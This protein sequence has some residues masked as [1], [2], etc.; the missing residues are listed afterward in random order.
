MPPHR[1]RDAVTPSLL[2]SPARV[3]PFLGD[4][5]LAPVIVRRREHQISG[6]DLVIFALDTDRMRSEMPIV[7]QRV[8]II[9]A[10]LPTEFDRHEETAA[11]GLEL[12]FDGE[13]AAVDGFERREQSA[14]LPYELVQLEA[15]SASAIRTYEIAGAAQKLTFETPSPPG[16]ATA[17]VPGRAG[18]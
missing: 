1:L 12:S 11:S 4:V 17:A 16:R 3:I 13:L 7:T 14:P 18:R 10:A 6:R 5:F 9:L 15:E 8:I 2:Q